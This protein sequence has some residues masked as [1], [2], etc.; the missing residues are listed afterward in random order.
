MLSTLNFLQ[1][2]RL[3]PTGYLLSLFQGSCL[4]G[5]FEDYLLCFFFLPTLKLSVV[6]PLSLWL[7]P[8]PAYH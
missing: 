2:G 6:A 1:N 5:V 7:I 4:N 8:T 3:V